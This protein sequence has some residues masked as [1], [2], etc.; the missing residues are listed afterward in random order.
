MSSVSE[1]TPSISPDNG[2]LPTLDLAKSYRGRRVEL[3]QEYGRTNDHERKDFLKKILQEHT[4]LLLQENRPI[5]SYLW[6]A[7]KN[8]HTVFLFG[9]LHK[10]LQKANDLENLNPVTDDLAPFFKTYIHPVVWKAFENSEQF[11][12]EIFNL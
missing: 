12:I 11:Y 7:E 1:L 2:V 6:K 8:G 3:R 10:T 5:K 9:D 4:N